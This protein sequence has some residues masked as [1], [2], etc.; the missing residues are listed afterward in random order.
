[1]QRCFIPPSSDFYRM[2]F[3][4]IL[5]LCL[6][7]WFSGCA[8]EGSVSQQT[9]DTG[10]EVVETDAVKAKKSSPVIMFFG[11]SLSAGYGIDP[12]DSFPGL[13]QHR[14]DSLGYDVEV[15]NAGV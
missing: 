6:L 14:L 8:E 2:N 9:T 11:N 7:I 10:S 13:I 4:K 15:V 5:L 1:M 12:D 3:N